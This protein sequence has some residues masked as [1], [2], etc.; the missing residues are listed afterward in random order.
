MVP[1]L[2]LEIPCRLQIG[3]E[4]QRRA[5]EEAR[6]RDPHYDFERRTGLLSS[7]KD[8]TKLGDTT[9]TMG[10]T[11]YD[12]SDAE[13][14]Y[15]EEFDPTAPTPLSAA[16]TVRSATVFLGTVFEVTE[17]ESRQGDR[18]SVSI[19]ISDGTTGIYLKKSCPIEDKAWIKALSVGTPVAAF[20][21]VLRDKFDNEPFG[22]LRGIKKIRASTARSSSTPA[23][24]TC[25]HGVRSTALAS[26]WQYSSLRGEI[27]PYTSM[28]TMR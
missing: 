16:E 3:K 26:I 24:R 22:A 4:Q 7:E 23:S 6:E 1:L 25:F 18:N 28:K 19:G 10:I 13:Q 9:F 8:N 5:E 11:T 21:R 12:V 17:K 20:C 27:S 15:G 14:V 2:P